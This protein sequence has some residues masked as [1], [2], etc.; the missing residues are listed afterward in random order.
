MPPCRCHL[1]PPGCPCRCELPQLHAFF[2]A[3]FCSSACPPPPADRAYVIELRVE[4]GVEL[5]DE[6]VVGRVNVAMPSKLRFAPVN[7]LKTNC[8]W[9][10]PFAA[11]RRRLPQ[12]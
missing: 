10:P 3:P 7:P 8:S 4:D 6:E 11:R 9:P 12:T 5:N 2:P 1:P